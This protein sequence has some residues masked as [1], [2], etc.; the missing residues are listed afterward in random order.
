MEN[1]T[2]PKNSLIFKGLNE[3]DWIIDT[4]TGIISFKSIG[5]KQYARMQPK[6]SDN[7]L[8][9]FEERGNISFSKATYD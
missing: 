2:L 3:Y 6:L 5:Y 8:I 4:T 7:Q 9:D 1:P